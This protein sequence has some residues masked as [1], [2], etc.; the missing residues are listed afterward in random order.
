VE[1]GTAGGSLVSQICG[2]FGHQIGDR[3]DRLSSA[4]DVSIGAARQAASSQTVWRR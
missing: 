1:D 2:G 3:F 4:M